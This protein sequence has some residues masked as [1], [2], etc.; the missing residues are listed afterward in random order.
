LACGKSEGA[1]PAPLGVLVDS[2]QVGAQQFDQELVPFGEAAA[3]TAQ[4]R[5]R[6][7]P[8]GAGRQATISSS[9]P[10][11]RRY[12]EYIGALCTGPEPQLGA[13]ASSG[14]RRLAALTA[15]R[16]VWPFIA[17]TLH[18]PTPSRAAALIK[19]ARGHTR[20]G[21]PMRDYLLVTDL[22]ARTGKGDKR[23]RDALV[24]RS[25]PL[26]WS[27][28]RRYRLGDADARAVSQSIWRQLVNQLDEVQDPGALAGSR[29]PAGMRKCAV[30]GG[31]LQIAEDNA[32]AGHQPGHQAGTGEQERLVAERHAALREAFSRLSPWLPAAAHPAHRRPSHAGRRDQRPAGH[33]RRQHRAGLPPLPG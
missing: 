6:D 7:L 4:S 12:S 1:G 5:R 28:C 24:E 11:R 20:G 8:G 18:L 26:I 32:G 16:A 25:S 33:P 9:T 21:D 3:V 13:L 22:A 23:A 2:V 14:Q 31:G 30:C 17:A 10:K 27:I 15:L 29:R 19:A